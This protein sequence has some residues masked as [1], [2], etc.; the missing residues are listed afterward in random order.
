MPEP[1][2]LCF[3]FY[4]VIKLVSIASKSYSNQVN[5][6]M[7]MLR[8]WVEWLQVWPIRFHY[9]RFKLHV[10]FS[11]KRR[12]NCRTSNI[13]KKLLGQIFKKREVHEKKNLKKKGERK[14]TSMTADSRYVVDVWKSQ[15]SS[16][17]GIF[18]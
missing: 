17:N 14:D 8:S 7:I 11:N 2:S 12:I 5:Y 15:Q 16:P 1:K 18:T 4:F 9:F 6:L 10:M 13:W 3:Y